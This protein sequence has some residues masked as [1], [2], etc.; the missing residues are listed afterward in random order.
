MSEASGLS[1]ECVQRPV[2]SEISLQSAGARRSWSCIYTTS[3]LQREP[4]LAVL[5]TS[6]ALSSEA[7]E[8]HSIDQTINNLSRLYC[9]VYMRSGRYHRP[10]TDHDG[11]HCS[12]SV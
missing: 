11:P 6:N 5:D 2:R 3:C 1:K 12:P 9:E 4:L 8:P 7:V 10:I